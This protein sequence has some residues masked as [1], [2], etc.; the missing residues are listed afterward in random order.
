MPRLA[1]LLETY[2]DFHGSARLGKGDEVARTRRDMKTAVERE[3][4]A[5]TARGAAAGRAPGTKRGGASK[6]ATASRQVDG[7]RSGERSS[8]MHVGRRVDYAV[9]ALA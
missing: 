2:V 7:S 8:L 5:R 1:V 9:R 6:Q 3:N 4:A